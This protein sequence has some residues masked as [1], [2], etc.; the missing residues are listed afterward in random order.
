MNKSPGSESI[1]DFPYPIDAVAAVADF[2]LRLHEGSCGTCHEVRCVTGP[3]VWD[4]EQTRV[5]YEQNAAATPFYE[6]GPVDTTLLLSS[7]HLSFT[8][9]RP[10]RRST[11][12]RADRAE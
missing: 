9:R 2:D 4:Y 8:F 7:P 3:I 12:R 5:N 6:A 10:S 1:E 11:D